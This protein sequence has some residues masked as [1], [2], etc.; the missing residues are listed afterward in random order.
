[1]IRVTEIIEK[2][3][4]YLLCRFNNGIVKKLDILPIIK[5]HTI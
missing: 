4:Y 1:M 2:N 3:P 5:N